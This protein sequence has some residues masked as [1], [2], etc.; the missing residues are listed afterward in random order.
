M[1]QILRLN[2]VQCYLDDLL[3]TGKDDED[4]LRNLNAT[5]QRLKEYGLW[6]KKDKCDFFKPTIEY[7]GHVI[8]STGLHKA[9]SKVKALLDVLGF[10]GLLTYYAKFMPNLSSRLRP[11][12][13]LLNKSNKWKWSDKCE[14]AFRDV[15]CTLT[16]SEVLT[17]YNPALPI[18]LACDAS[19]Y[20]VGAVLSHVMPSGEER[21]IAFA[22]RTLNSAESNYAQ[23]EREALAIVFGVK[24][25]HQYLFGRRFTLLTDHRPLTSI[26]GNQTGIPS[27]AANCMQG[28]AL[29]LSAHQY[30]IKYKMSEQHCNAD[31][32]SKL[33]LPDTKPECPQCNIF[34]FQEV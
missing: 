8:D 12:H 20:G 13:E 22:S 10:L 7:L 30:D 2:G 23:I 4:Y 11:L 26:F 25:F 18:Q 3:I 9:P 19:P 15:K 33:P 28:C 1:D 24:K 27:L 5:L 32:L 21:P 29:L 6:V 16:Q 34:Y 14:K 17:H 31:G